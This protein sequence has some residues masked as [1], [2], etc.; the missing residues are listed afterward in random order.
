MIRFKC[1]SCGER[2]EVDEKHSGKATKCAKCKAPLTVPIR[3]VVDG[4]IEATVPLRP[5]E[6]TSSSVPKS[7]ENSPSTSV[8]VSLEQQKLTGFQGFL[9]AFGI[10]SGF[11]AALVAAVIGLPMLLCGGCLISMLGAGTA[12][13]TPS[14]SSSQQISKKPKNDIDL[15]TSGVQIQSTE[16]QHSNGG[17]QSSSN[18][19]ES[20]SINTFPVVDLAEQSNIF[21]F[22]ELTATIRDQYINDV[23]I[24][25]L[26]A[27]P[28]KADVL[29]ENSSNANWKPNVRLEFINAYGVVLGD[30]SIFWALTALEPNKRYTESINFNANRFDNIFRYSSIM[31]PTD[32]DKPKYLKLVYR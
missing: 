6:S 15:L 29:F 1:L 20:D 4:P 11:M 22:D 12:V 14:R 8:V 17:I 24:L 25:D 18:T 9:R 21:L 31:K 28:V 27:N 13:E 2:Y 23:R 10:T 7:Q 3:S 5:N 30:A 19:T 26:N 32:F 16:S